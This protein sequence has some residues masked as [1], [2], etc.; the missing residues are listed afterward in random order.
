[1]NKNITQFPVKI[2]NSLQSSFPLA[3]VEETLDKNPAHLS[4]VLPKHSFEPSKE[5]L[6]RIL[7]YSKLR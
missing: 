6:D 3:I 5:V 1:M 7:T 4:S 2:L